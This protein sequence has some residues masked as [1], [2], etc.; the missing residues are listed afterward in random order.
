MG[1]EGDRP[2]FLDR[3]DD[4]GEVGGDEGVDTAEE[5]AGVVVVEMGRMIASATTLVRS[6]VSF[7]GG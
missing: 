4:T 3:T 7:S 6:T 5:A 1:E 2:R